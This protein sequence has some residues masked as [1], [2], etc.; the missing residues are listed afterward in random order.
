[1]RGLVKIIEH[2]EIGWPEF[3]ERAGSA[4]EKGP[5]RVSV[6][7]KHEWSTVQEVAARHSCSPKTIRKR[8]YDGSLKAVDIS[9]AGSDVRQRR[10][11][12]HRDA[13]KAWMDAKGQKSRQTARKASPTGRSFR[14]LV[15]K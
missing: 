4:L 5:V 7:P 14:D 13:E 3:Y 2:R 8:I 6:K 1:V 12:I 10:Y 15:G 11:R 9:P